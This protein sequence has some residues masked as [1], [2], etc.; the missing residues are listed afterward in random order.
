MDKD[1]L[2][3]EYEGVLPP[4]RIKVISLQVG[5]WARDSLPV[6]VLGQDDKLTVIDAKYYHKVEPDKDIQGLFKTGLEKH[7]YYFEG[8]NFQA[9]HK[10]DCLIVNNGRHAKIPDDIFT[11]LYGCRTLTRL[12]FIDGIG[13]VDERARFINEKTIVTDTP[14]YKKILQAKGF[15]VSL[16]PRPKQPYETYVNSLILNGHVVV[17]VFGQQTD[18]QALAVYEKLGLKASGADSVT[19]SNVGEGSIHCIT[20]TY[21]AI[22]MPELLKFLR[23]KE[24]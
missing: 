15:S 10:G 12:P 14:E 13:H 5:F 17:P 7:N 8:G 18:A 16:L 21:P 11:G 2:L 20:M 19:L 9:N 6:P 22:P 3:R 24:F 4:S 1:T 23:A